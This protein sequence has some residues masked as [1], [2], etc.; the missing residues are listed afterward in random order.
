MASLIR[1]SSEDWTKRTWDLPTTFRGL[2]MTLGVDLYNMP[3]GKPLAAW[4][5]LKK[6]QHLP[7]YRACPDALKLEIEEYLGQR[8]PLEKFNPHHDQQG[9]FASA[10]EEA[11]AKPPARRPGMSVVER[12]E[13]DKKVNGQKT[14]A[15][16]GMKRRTGVR[17]IGDLR[18][19]DVIYER[20]GMR[21]SYSTV[22]AIRPATSPWGPD[23]P[24]SKLP[25]VKVLLR[26]PSGFGSWNNFTADEE[27][28]TRDDYTV[29]NYAAGQGHYTYVG[30]E[31]EPETVYGGPEITDMNQPN[32]SMGRGEHYKGDALRRLGTNWEAFP[33]AARQVAIGVDAVSAKGVPAAALE[34]ITIQ[35]PE[36]GKIHTSH[37]YGSDAWAWTQGQ[38]ID[39]SSNYVYATAKEYMDK[40]V[41]GEGVS[42]VADRYPMWDRIGPQDNDVYGL[43]AMAYGDSVASGFHPDHDGY[44]GTTAVAVHE[45]GHALLNQIARY[46]G[47][48]SS[49][50]RLV[51]LTDTLLGPEGLDLQ[52]SRIRQQPP[53]D[54]DGDRT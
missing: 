17:S 39:F 30:T 15:M 26:H 50:Q 1:T 12:M 40:I 16:K 14:S 41:K 48:G 54:F 36:E 20:R 46:G 49:H 3:P 13:F 24:K 45:I 29:R 33:E 51:R 19:G 7:S 23:N 34:G 31:P 32:Q 27:V 52:Q 43:G 18:P 6:F 5:V 22:E 53:G 21:P 35:A 8:P 2:V 9:Q 37:G 25:W 10:D 38:N 28:D 4:K 42:T 44:S 47:E 11:M